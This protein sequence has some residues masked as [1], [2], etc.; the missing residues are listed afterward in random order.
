MRLWSLHPQYLDR[1]GLLALWREALLAQA[2]LHGSTKAYLNHPQLQRFKT[3][4]HPLDAIAFYLSIVHQESLQRG[5]HFDPSKFEVK[6]QA[7][8]IP[9]TKGQYDFEV[10]HLLS[11]LER[12]SVDDFRRLSTLPSFDL[13]P[14]FYLVPGGIEA[15]EKG[16]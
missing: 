7:A 8:P 1:Q 13:H 15:W 5:Y 11:K 9:V 14:L 4:P 16:K 3:Q 6:R 12:R 2:V 10:V